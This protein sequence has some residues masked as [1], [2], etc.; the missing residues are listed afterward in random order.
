MG[1]Q[2]TD[3]ETWLHDN[4]DERI[5]RIW[6]YKKVLEPRESYHPYEA[7]SAYENDE[8]LYVYIQEVIEMGG[9][10]F[11]FGFV[12]AVSAQNAWETDTSPSII[13]MMDGEFS[14]EYCPEDFDEIVG[15]EAESD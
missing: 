4:A 13:Y 2:W 8:P 3:L 11:L 12:D 10:R 14:M 15:S 1:K 5:F 7:I 9:G 6:K